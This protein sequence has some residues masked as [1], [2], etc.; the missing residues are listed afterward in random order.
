M[1]DDF[2]S[3][4]ERES[5]STLRRKYEA[6]LGEKANLERE[7]RAV[8]AQAILVEKGYSRVTVDDL[9]DVSLAELEA[10]AA[11]LESQKEQH[12]ADILRRV[13]AG[14][15]LKDGEIES[16]VKELLGMN[17]Q[18]RQLQALDRIRAVG[19]TGGTPPGQSE[20]PNLFGPSRIRAAYANS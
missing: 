20:D 1:A 14:K 2:E 6:V 11:E 17:E 4:D 19:R 7:L 9:A 10:K 13:L 12:E 3:E 16:A 5:G 15:G 18:D 8:K